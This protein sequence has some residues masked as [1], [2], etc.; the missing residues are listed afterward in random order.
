MSEMTMVERV[1]IAM[2]NAI[3]AEHDLSPIKDMSTVENPEHFRRQAR[4]AIA[5]MRDSPIM[6]L[7]IGAQEYER[8]RHLSNNTQRMRKSWQAMID[9][10]LSSSVPATSDPS[11]INLPDLG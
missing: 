11:G 10:A 1:S 5:A 6:T 9:A 4:A 3:R 7:A 8:A 2:C